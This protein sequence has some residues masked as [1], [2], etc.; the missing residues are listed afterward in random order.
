MH[1]EDVGEA[2][3]RQLIERNQ[4]PA[5]ILWTECPFCKFVPDLSEV[6]E[7]STGYSNDELASKRLV[8]HIGH[9]L[10]SISTLALPWRNDLMDDASSELNESAKARDRE[11]GSQL[12][13]SEV[14]ETNDDDE[15]DL[16][17]Y[18]L[19][20]L[21]IPLTENQQWDMDPADFEEIDKDDPIIQHLL[22][23]HTNDPA[24]SE[25]DQSV[26]N[27]LETL[28]FVTSTEQPNNSKYQYT[29]LNLGCI[30]L[31]H[32]YP[33]E[34]GQPIYC[35]LLIASLHHLPAYTYLSYTWGASIARVGIQMEAPTAPVRIRMGGQSCAVVTN[36]FAALMAIRS[37]DST[38]TIWV[39]ALCIN[40]IDVL[41]RH[42]QAQL[43]LQ[44]AQSA[45]ETIVWLGESTE[46]SDLAMSFVSHYDDIVAKGLTRDE[47]LALNKALISL[48][49]RPWWSRVWMVQE[50]ITS[51][52]VVV[53][54][55]SSSTPFEKFVDLRKFQLPQELQR[56]FQSV[57]QPIEQM[58]FGDLLWLW[59]QLRLKIFQGR[60]TLFS[61]MM[62]MR[63]LQSTDPRD[64][65]YS[66]LALCRKNDRSFIP[67][68][69]QSYLS[70]YT[71]AMQ[72][73]LRNE[74][75]LPLYLVEEHQPTESSILPSWVI[76]WSVSPLPRAG[77]A[78]DGQGARRAYRSCGLPKDQEKF[79]GNRITFPA[80]VDKDGFF[81]RG[82][83]LDTISR[84]CTSLEYTGADTIS[85]VLVCR[86]WRSVY[87]AGLRDI[88]ADI[89]SGQ[90]AFWRTLVA[91]RLENFAE[92][93]T[94][95][96]FKDFKS[97][98]E[99]EEEEELG[100]S[101]FPKKG[102]PDDRVEALIRRS[103]ETR[104]FAMTERGYPALVPERARVGDIVCVLL[105]GDVPF[106]LRRGEENYTII[107][108]AYIH[109][110]MDG[111]ALELVEDGE[112][113]IEDF[114]IC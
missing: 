67:D 55:G 4:R 51:S 76:D 14:G 105:G 19:D 8:K 1:N 27:T 94:I 87:L 54:C 23:N 46:D 68:Y 66:A 48:F 6:A 69:S 71:E 25:N 63:K 108:E 7:V 30:R 81:C 39:D 97:L 95:D 42:S 17:A 90:E 24:R 114:S 32:L 99:E 22:F 10:Q 38:L 85:L 47:I 57:I 41:E 79:F 102:H 20:V 44:I 109:G 61:L 59:D 36:L 33:G 29:P 70:I 64:K 35:D 72:L 34:P 62:A 18:E 104:T 40:Q 3:L 96:F 65:V 88:Y 111:K 9:H 80:Q 21:T 82:I 89:E 26:M 49:V 75:I 11:A 110:F 74:G 52:S 13:A 101:F 112:K 16:M 37:G 50:V 113:Y 93:P 28:S 73:F 83:L 78:F 31:L 100:F 12:D 5:P 103:C 53:I 91:N 92:E 107:G 77:F 45:S 84:R 43:M 56:D 15:T 106:V 58:P 2:G 98:L 86:N 60:A